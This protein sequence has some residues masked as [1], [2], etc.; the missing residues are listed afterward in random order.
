MRRSI[1]LLFLSV[2]PAAVAGTLEF[3]SPLDL[4]ITAGTAS[5]S[6]IASNDLSITRSL[7]DVS[8]SGYSATA[9]LILPGTFNAPLIQ[10][11]SPFSFALTD[12]TA[13]CGNEAGC[14]GNLDFNFSFIVQFDSGFDELANQPMSPTISY[15]GF[16]SSITA[17]PTLTDFRLQG[18]FT[19]TLNNVSSYFQ[20]YALFGNGS[21]GTPLTATGLAN[22]GSSGNLGTLAVNGNLR[23]TGLSKN[24]NLAIQSVDYTFQPASAV[25]E[26]ATVT[27][28][29]FGLT[30]GLLLVRRRWTPL[31]AARIFSPRPAGPECRAAAP[32][33]PETLAGNDSVPALP[34]S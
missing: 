32:G 6:I 2:A 30:A 18:S 22:F 4:Q 25:P 11:A 33:L 24:A 3:I 29:L 26:P 34:R 8:G 16:F 13:S 5:G 31:I 17:I 7:Y 1:L 21:F 15:A 14:S 20:S 19:N 28:V 27:F 10:Q 23:L 9:T 12:I